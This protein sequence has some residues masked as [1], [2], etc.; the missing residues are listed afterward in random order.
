[1]ES[2]FMTDC[3]AQ[4]L[5]NMGSHVIIEYILTANLY[6]NLNLL[7]QLYTRLKILLLYLSTLRAHNTNRKEVVEG[8]TKPNWQFLL[9]PIDSHCLLWKGN[10]LDAFSHCLHEPTKHLIHPITSHS[11]G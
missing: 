7:K 2:M 9:R 10:G 4:Q 6:L 1:M 11:T 5:D 8:E 3:K